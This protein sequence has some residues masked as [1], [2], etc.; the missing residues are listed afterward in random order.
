MQ[1]VALNDRWETFAAAHREALEANEGKPVKG[2]LFLNGVKV[3]PFE[4][5][6]E[7]ED[8]YEFV[9]QKLKDKVKDNKE[10]AKADKVVKDKPKDKKIK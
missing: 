6:L 4:S 10:D 1:Y 3:N 8:S 9:T 2:K 5:L 7:A